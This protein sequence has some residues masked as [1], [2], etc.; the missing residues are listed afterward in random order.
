MNQFEKILDK[1]ISLLPKTIKFCNRCVLSNQRPRIRINDEGY[2]SA[3]E[4]AKIKQCETDWKER[5]LML[6]NL[7]D[8]HRRKDGRFDVIVPA[9][10][11]K[12]SARV[13]Y[14]LKYKYN[15]HPL[16]ITYA[17]FEYT[18]IGYKNFRN[19]TKIGGFNNIMA[20]PNGAVHRKLSRLSFEAI[21]DGFQPFVYG[22]MGYTFHMAKA[23]DIKLV[24]YGENGEAEYS[25]DSKVYGLSGMPLKLW[26]EQYFKGVTIDDIIEYGLE[27]DLLKENEFDKTDLTFYKP[28]PIENLQDNGTEFHWFSF[29]KKWI[30]Q[31]NYYLAS[32]H[33][34]FQANPEGRS[35]GTYSKYASLDDEMDGFHY[36]LAF[37]K[38]GIGRCTSDAAHEIRDEHITREEGM[39]LVKR[40]DG[41]FP[42]FH[43]KKFLNYLDIT[44]EHFWKVINKFR[45]PHV[46]KRVND[47]WRLNSSI[48]D[49]DGLSKDIPVY[50]SSIPQNSRILANEDTQK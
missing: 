48:Y 43:F 22:Q 36:Y 5:E 28:P 33:T 17:P 40:Y 6:R 1:Q 7:C 24:F 13:A 12:D 38:F 14:E 44:E 21:G 41:E 19:F 47:E 46:W 30:P 45:F 18:P 9:S 31:E 2:C 27:S 23:F 35:E 29:Y 10:G 20:W 49:L 11:G 8:E 37:I 32:E 25:G 26:K 50:A 39:A 34:G 16:T 4:F 3:C 15:M 42:R